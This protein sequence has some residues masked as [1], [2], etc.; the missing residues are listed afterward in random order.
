MRS[1]WF[2]IYPTISG[3]VCCARFA[4][5]FS[6]EKECLRI[7]ELDEGDVE[8]CGVEEFVVMRLG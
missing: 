1:I 7:V 8:G 3:V 6:C 4:S 5:L 2:F